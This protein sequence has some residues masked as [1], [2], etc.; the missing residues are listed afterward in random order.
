MEPSSS[1]VQELERPLPPCRVTRDL[2]RRVV[3]LAQVWCEEAL[4]GSTGELR[5]RLQ[6]ELGAVQVDAMTEL[7]LLADLGAIDDVEMKMRRRFEEDELELHF[8]LGSAHPG[9]LYA[10]SIHRN[11]LPGL[12]ALVADVQ[13]AVLSAEA[14]AQR[15]SGSQRM[16]WEMPSLQVDR[17]SLA[18]LEE[19]LLGVAARWFRSHRAYAE[20]GWR[21]TSVADDGRE[22]T[23]RSIAA[24]AAWP[25]SL[26]TRLTLVLELDAASEQSTQAVDLTVSLVPHRRDGQSSTVTLSATG[27]H[28]DRLVK[29]LEGVL[30][31]WSTQQQSHWDQYGFHGLLRIVAI[32]S[33]FP[34]GIQLVEHIDHWTWPPSWQAL[35]YVFLFFA[36]VLY[37]MMRRR[38]W[39][40]VW[41]FDASEQRRRDQIVRVFVTAESILLVGVV[42]PLLLG[43]L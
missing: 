22:E 11:G 18:S 37:L 30:R 33:L 39:P 3:E 16:S 9:V 24:L 29:E 31:Q 20:R 5:A 23:V 43:K 40:S 21:I 26:D 19:T 14:E 32:I 34:V 15:L 42:L 35:V 38:L 12:R 27:P 25:P 36:L 7:D 6:T 1:V 41:Y 17:A 10:L 28:A 4:P 2:V 8:H 13:R